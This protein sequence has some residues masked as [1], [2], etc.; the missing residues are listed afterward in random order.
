M[1]NAPAP[2]R[3]KKGRGAMGAFAP[4]LG[5]WVAEADS[6]M[7]PVAC[8]RD[9]GP[10]GPK[11]V[12]L[13]AEWVFAAPG[14]DAPKTY[15]ETCFFLPDDT[16]AVQFFSF[17][18]DGKR[19]QGRLAPADDI[20]PDALAFE[21]EMPGGLARQVYW[22]AEEGEGFHWAVERRTK[23]GWSRFVDHHYRPLRPPA[24]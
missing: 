4:L 15:R 12:R 7:G 14:G 24:G 11:Q 13:E 8:R 18:S 21:A 6:P 10:F 16:D 22:P 23:S 5:R 20:H 3:W 9:F 2:R 17:T 19:S 1:T